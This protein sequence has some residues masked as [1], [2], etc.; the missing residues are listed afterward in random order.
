LIV[1]MLLMNMED[2]K[3]RSPRWIPPTIRASTLALMSDI[4]DVFFK[5]LRGMATV[6]ALYTAGA[7]IILLAFNVPYAM[8]LGV[9]FGALY[10]VP[11]I[12]TLINLVVLFLV[13][14]LSGTNGTFFLPAFASPWIYAMIVLVVYIG[15]G[16]VFDHMIYPQMVG[17]SVGLNGVVSLFVIACGYALFGLVGMI[18]A[19]PLAGS[20]KV[21][22]DRLI[23]VTSTTQDGLK[24]PAVPLRHRAT[25]A[26]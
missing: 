8:L 1:W 15:F 3:R 19:F 9:L 10:I 14:G 25:P 23:R 16:F 18:I 24:L 4:G 20:A 6:V 11:Y 17:A 21:I 22:L 12:G 7:V 26:G 2:F 13:I 5:Y